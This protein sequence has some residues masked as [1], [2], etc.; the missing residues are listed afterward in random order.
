MTNQQDVTAH[1]IPSGLRRSVHTTSAWLKHVADELGHEDKQKAY[2]ALR[3]VLFAL[4]DRLP[5]DEVMNLSAQLPTL[6]RG[7]YF[8]G[9]KAAGKPERYRDQ[10]EFF[11]RVWEE[12]EVVDGGAPEA[13][14]RAVLAMLE[15][16]VSEG[17]IEDIQHM[18]PA[19]LNSLWDDE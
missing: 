12:L 2:H 7:V 19:S 15:D 9:Y 13:A 4:R 18:L 10:D 6:I 14:T 1:D 17:E 8:E 11:D 3:G 16:K 5:V